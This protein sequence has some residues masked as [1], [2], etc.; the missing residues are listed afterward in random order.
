LKKFSSRC[1]CP[2]VGP[3]A[4]PTPH[5]FKF[6]FLKF[7]ISNLKSS[8]KFKFE[9]EIYISDFSEST[10][11]GLII[12]QSSNNAPKSGIIAEARR[13][14]FNSQF[15]EKLDNNPK[16]MCFSNGVVDFGTKEF[17][18]GKPEDYLTK[19]TNTNFITVDRSH[20][21]VINE[22]NDFMEKLFPD[23]H[24]LRYMWERLA[25]TLIGEQL[26]QT[27]HMYIGKG[28]NGKSMLVT[29][30]DRVLGEYKGDVPLALLT[31]QRIKIGGLAPELLQIKGARLAV[32]QEP[33]KKD[34]INDGAMKQLTGGDPVQARSPYMLVYS[35]SFQNKWKHIAY[36]IN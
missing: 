13:T 15:Y 5:K 7:Q 12:K 27:I 6:N 10:V 19:C 18:N 34:V 23:R 9:F 35:S 36:T 29:L 2:I 25:S 26:D 16:L 8:S 21:P 3:S 11:L 22:I 20:Q 1:I 31:Q 30:M 14:F 32:I 4:I 24:L 28:Q 33:S 17:R